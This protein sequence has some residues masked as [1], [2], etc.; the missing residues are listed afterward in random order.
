[1]PILAPPKGPVE[2]LV[3]MFLLGYSGT[4]KTWA[5]VALGIP[6]VVPGWPGMKLRILD[7]D[8]KGE[9][10]VNAV[11]SLHK[12][13]KAITQEQYEAAFANFDLCLCSENMGVI[14]VKEPN[15]K[16]VKKYGVKGTATAWNTAVRQVEKWEREGWDKSHVLI[17]DSFTYAVHALVNARQ[18]LNGR[19][20]QPLQWQGYADPQSEVE[21]FLAQIA[22][23]QANV[24][25]TGHQ[26]PLEI[27]KDTGR[28]DDK[29]Q[30]VQEL[31]ES[32][33]LPISV[34]KAKRVQLPAL[35]NHMLVCGTEG[36]GQGTRRYIYTTPY[37]GVETKTPFY[38]RCK[39][40]YPI[41]KGM[42]E[43][44]MLRG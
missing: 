22:S 24:I 5:T 12:Q 8:G 3:K 25:I 43:Y 38:G 7:F 4:G 1:M 14:S 21:T 16:T 40:A 44:F 15:G 13:Q 36:S 9:E 30:P 34:G 20:N 33:M 18:E 42:V 11:L 32:L 23:V 35:M 6:G 27:Y 39:S 26:D 41:D 29:G 28:K 2:H 17:I 19:L 31:V 37:S 10:I